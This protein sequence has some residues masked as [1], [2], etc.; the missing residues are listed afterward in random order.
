[1]KVSTQLYGASLQSLHCGLKIIEIATYL[2]AGV[3]NE[4]HS[5]ILR[6]MNMLDIII[7]RQSKLC[8]D[9][10]RRVGASQLI[11]DERSS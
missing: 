2:A 4:G 8:A 3:F 9:D 5:F 6:I 1:M 7:G 10:K 11:G